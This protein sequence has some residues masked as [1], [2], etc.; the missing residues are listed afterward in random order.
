MTSTQKTYNVK[1]G[2]E[3]EKQSKITNN[4]T[5]EEIPVKKVIIEDEFKFIDYNS[6][7]TIEYLIEYFLTTFS[8]YKKYNFCKS[9]F[10]V[11]Y[12]KN[13]NYMLLS[14]NIKKKLSDFNQ[15]NLFLILN[16][17]E[18][19]CDFQQ[20][21]IYMNLSKFV[22]IDL[23]YD[24]Q[25]LVDKSNKIIRELQ[26]KNELSKKNENKTN[27]THGS[28]YDIIIDIN[29]IK[30]VNKD[31]WKIKFDE[32]GL[33]N[34]KKYKDKNMVVIGVLGNYNKGK[35]FLLSKIVKLNFM[36]GIST[37]GLSIKYPELKNRKYILLDTVGIDKPI[38]NNK[39]TQF[40]NEKVGNYENNNGQYNVNNIKKI[41][42][43]ILDNNLKNMF[44]MN[45][46][47]DIS[48]ILLIVVGKLTYSEQLLINT[49]KEESKRR[50]KGKIF[51]IHNLKEFTKTEQ[52]K[53]YIENSLLQFSTFDIK[54]RIWIS[55]KKDESNE[56]AKNKINDNKIQEDSI[57]NNINFNDD[58]KDSDNFSEEF[59]EEE[60]IDETKNNDNKPANFHFVETINF[61]EGK[62]L[63]MYHFII[64]NEY[65]EAGKVYNQYTYNFIEYVYYLII[66]PK[67]IDIFEQIKNNFKKFSN[68]LINNNIEEIHFNDNEKIIQ[69]KLIKLELEEEISLK[70]YDTNVLDSYFKSEDFI[71]KYNYFKPD[72]NTL[73]IRVEVPGNIQCNVTHKVEDDKTII[74]IIGKKQKDKI[75]RKNE[76]NLFNTREFSE[77]EINIPL[78][79]QDFKINERKP[80]EGFPRF[81]NGIC[82]IQYELASKAGEV[83]CNC[84]GL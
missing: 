41:K 43:N 26:E 84:K 23:L 15:E 44:L 59:I 12:M 18:C 38:L 48:D 2:R 22:L 67:K 6:Y 40:T 80:K 54:R 62:K 82:I 17:H 55:S 20:F 75:P 53:N 14:R 4:K 9:Q 8:Q 60:Y 31:G 49:I 45:F 39:S 58:V 52:V 35:S 21:H 50:K 11:Y 10:S 16:P 79:I 13:N 51:I 64:A 25:K 29:S 42:E 61:G 66:E 78:L 69:D 5:S 77:F 27:I 37:E 70:R 76:D 3:S 73:E 63:E 19:N 57:Y 1:F 7:S 72:E 65:S 46:I 30:G 28:F 36:T 47:L 32:D 56:K 83:S 24:M 34:Y 71:P 74:T 68:S 33:N 81:F